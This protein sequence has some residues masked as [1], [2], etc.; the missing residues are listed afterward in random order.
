MM[1]IKSLKAER[2]NLKTKCV[3]EKEKAIS[4]SYEA[5]MANNATRASRS[6]LL[7]VKNNFEKSLKERLKV[8]VALEI[9]AKDGEVQFQKDLLKEKEV[10]MKDL[11]EVNY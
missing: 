7:K 10:Q 9:K 3:R 11:R 8:Q 1:L 5:K 6:E 2:R 4:K